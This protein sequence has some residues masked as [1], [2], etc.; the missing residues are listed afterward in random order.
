[1]DAEKEFAKLYKQFENDYDLSSLNSSNDRMNLESFIRNTVHIR[2]I[3]SEIDSLMSGANIAA[4][5]Q[6]IKRLSD[7][8]DSISEKN[9]ALERALGI[10]RKSRKKDNQVSTAEYI[11]HLQVA[12][13]E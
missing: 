5:S 8:K 6:D 13:Q 11:M 2:R 9:L 1:M 12:A 3:D 10:D 4:N 7:V